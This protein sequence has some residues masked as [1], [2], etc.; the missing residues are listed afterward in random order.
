MRWCC[1][2]VVTPRERR[3]SHRGTEETYQIKATRIHTYSMVRTTKTTGIAGHMKRWGA[4]VAQPRRVCARCWSSGCVHW[5]W[6]HR[7]REAL[8]AEGSEHGRVGCKTA[9]GVQACTMC[10]CVRACVCMCRV[11][12]PHGRE[13]R[14]LRSLHTT[15]TE[16]R[17][18]RSA[19]RKRL[20]V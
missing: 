5:G 11:A 20:G 7:P 6:T 18:T 15:S 2:A 13:A 17:G 14:A 3:D 12:R 1:G 9:G 16:V 8:E 19:Q 4:V 10:A